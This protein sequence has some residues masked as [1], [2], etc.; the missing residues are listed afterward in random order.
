MCYQ[1]KLPLVS[2]RNVG[3]PGKSGPLAK[4]WK[5]LCEI[6]AENLPQPQS[7]GSTIVPLPWRLQRLA[8]ASAKQKIGFIYGSE[9]N[10]G[11]NFTVYP[12]LHGWYGVDTGV[13]LLV[14][15][16]PGT[17]GGLANLAAHLVAPRTPET[18]SYLVPRLVR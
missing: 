1:K 13:S 3:G 7:C 15:R 10:F 6:A 2:M 12:W 17:L 4:V 18:Y 11:G 9:P 5:W 16:Q 14:Y 8:R